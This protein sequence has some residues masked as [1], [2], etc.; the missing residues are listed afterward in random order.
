VRASL[1]FLLVSFVA[2]TPAAPRIARRARPGFMGPLRAPLLHDRTSGPGH[3]SVVLAHARTARAVDVAVAVVACFFLTSS[4]QPT[5]R[6]ACVCARALVLR[7]APRLL[8]HG[9]SWRVIGGTCSSAATSVPTSHTRRA[10]EC[11]VA[12]SE[13][14]RRTRAL[15]TAHASVVSFCAQEPLVLASCVVSRR[16]LE[17]YAASTRPR[18]P[19][20]GTFT[21]T[22]AK[23]ASACSPPPKGGWAHILE[24]EKRFKGAIG[25]SQ[26]A[27]N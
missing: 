6:S 9:P 5:P 18:I 27:Q 2:P 11:S 13:A 7:N 1:S 14:D 17:H 22:S 15:N 19:R 24:R 21:S 12:L 4:C 10:S 16:L 25:A 8:R 23:W 3:V 20:P 26:A